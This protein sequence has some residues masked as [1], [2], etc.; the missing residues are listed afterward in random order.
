VKQLREILEEAK[1]HGN[2][3]NKVVVRR[4]LGQMLTEGSPSEAGRQEGRTVLQEALALAKE[5]G[6]AHEI[7]WLNEL[8]EKQP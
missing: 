3:E 2:I 1:G 5:H 8:L 4:L 7:R 6:Y